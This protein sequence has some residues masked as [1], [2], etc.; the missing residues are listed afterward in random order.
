MSTTSDVGRVSDRPVALVT[1][2]ASGIGRATALR[3]AADGFHIVGLDRDSQGLA[4]WV[5]QVRGGGG[6]AS[7]IEA[8]LSDPDV[9]TRAISATL[10]VAGRLDALALVA[11]I[12]QFGPAESISVEQFD[13]VIAI[14]LRAPLLLTQAALPALR[15]SRGAIVA[16]SSI[17]G[18]Q[19]W[20]YAAAY[21]ASKGGLVTM[22]KSLALENGP[23]GVRVNV[24]VPGAVETGLA[25]SM[26]EPDFVYDESI[27]KR[28]T[29][30][31]GRKAEPSEI[32]GLV[33]FLVS[34][35]ASFVNGAVL[36]A[37]GG[38]FA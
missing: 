26:R 15:E 27:R 7:V 23:A 16:V 20:P 21:S 6:A 2:A 11:G 29:A 4:S 17:A 34:A 25:V 30:L 9:A 38:A 13:R 12:P 37:D 8:D 32:A 3:L 14:N 35:E 19:G 5:E 28:N 1:G 36:Q 31:D 18:V 24:L 33:S 22:M 10:D